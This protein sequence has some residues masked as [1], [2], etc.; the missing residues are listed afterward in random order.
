MQLEIINR[1]SDVDDGKP[2]HIVFAHNGESWAVLST[3]QII[4]VLRTVTRHF[5]SADHDKKVAFFSAPL[6]QAAAIVRQRAAE[7]DIELPGRFWLTA[8]E[9]DTGA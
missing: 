3:E 6:H 7:H 2:V 4:D 8:E 5:A 9:L 1:L